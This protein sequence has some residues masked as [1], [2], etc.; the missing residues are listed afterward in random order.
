MLRT[1]IMKLVLMF[2]LSFQVGCALL[3]V[4][5]SAFRVKGKIDN[6]NSG[7]Q[8]T[9]NLHHVGNG[10]LLTSKYITDDFQV[11]FIIP[12]KKDDYYLTVEC[13][14]RKNMLRSDNYQLGS[15]DHYK[16]PIDLGVIDNFLPGDK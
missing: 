2:L 6:L 9:L 14:G 16:N 7:N 12:A 13:E 8:C 4:S 1:R 5:D 15:I 10:K 11:T 3:T